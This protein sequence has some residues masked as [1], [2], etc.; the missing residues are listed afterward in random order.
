MPLSVHVQRVMIHDALHVY[1]QGHL[2]V[3]QVIIKAEPTS[4]AHEPRI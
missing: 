4:D 1:W 2:H 3:Q